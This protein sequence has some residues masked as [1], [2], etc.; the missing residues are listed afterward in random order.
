M[1]QEFFFLILSF[2]KSVHAD[3]QHAPPFSQKNKNIEHGRSKEPVW[4]KIFFELPNKISSN[5]Y[6]NSYGKSHA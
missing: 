5:G 3:A 6:Q 1:V 2:K 4:L